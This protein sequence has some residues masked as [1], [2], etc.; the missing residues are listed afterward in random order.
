MFEEPVVFVDIETSGSTAARSEIIEIAAIRV[1]KGEITQEFRTLIKPSRPLPYWITNLTGIKDGDL[2]NAPYF[3]E[4]APALKEILDGAIFIA[5]NVRFDYSFVKNQLENCGYKFNPKL[6]CTVRL[7]RKL[8]PYSKGHSLEK[9]I[10]RHNIMV[11]SRHRAYDDARAIKDFTALAF[12]EHGE[13]KF[14]QA[15]HDLLK[16]KTMPSNLKDSSVKNLKQGPGVYIFEDDKGLPVYIGKSINVKARVSS[17]F[18][19]SSR[20]GK[21]MKISMNTHNVRVMETGSEIEAL[22][23]ESKLI[24]DHLPL[25]NRQLRRKGN[26]YGVVK[27]IDDTG[28]YNFSIKVLSEEDIKESKNIYGIYSGKAKARRAIEDKLRTFDLCPKLLGLEKCKEAC[29][30]VQLKKCRGACINN[31]SSALYNLRVEIAFQKSKMENWPYKSPV[32][33]DF[34]KGEGVIVDNW[35]ILG[36]VSSSDDGTVNYKSEE[37][38][39]DIDSYRIIRGYINRFKYSVKIKPF[40]VP[41]SD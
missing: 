22:L 39:F 24:K 9:I 2:I 16:T 17:H 14:R 32:M 6:L 25:F 11:N 35:I 29:F 3:E 5:H 21:E 30:H 20:N 4:V 23:L 13:D 10:H 36:Y 28:Y 7:S 34:G 8:Y 19:E 15:V 1:D 12:T 38:I 31:E 37:S 27:T 26:Y 40:S 18:S 33:I 41:V